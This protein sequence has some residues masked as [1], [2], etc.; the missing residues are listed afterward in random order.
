MVKTLIDSRE[1]LPTRAKLPL[2]RHPKALFVDDDSHHRQTNDECKLGSQ[3]HAYG[4][5]FQWE[6]RTEV[7]ERFHSEFQNGLI[8]CA[9]CVRFSKGLHHVPVL[10]IQF[11][12]IHIRSFMRIARNTSDL[13]RASL[14]FS[15]FAT[16]HIN[17]MIHNR[18]EILTL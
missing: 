4:R 15:L 2:L 3:P 13:D 12:V 7:T 6:V 11:T 14:T 5:L 10:V 8:L 17:T 16:S 9:L 18:V 1:Y